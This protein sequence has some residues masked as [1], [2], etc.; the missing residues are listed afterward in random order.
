MVQVRMSQN[1]HVDAGRLDR[2]RLPIAQPQVL[3]PLKQSAIDQNPPTVD[4]E[5]V[6]GAGDRAGGAEERQ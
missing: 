3:E 4:L 6:L 2:Q 5:Q 1:D